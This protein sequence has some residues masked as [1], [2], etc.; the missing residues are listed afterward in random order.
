MSDQGPSRLGQLVDHGPL[1]PGLSHPAGRPQG[2][3]DPSANTRDSLSTPWALDK[4]WNRPGQLVEPA[5]PRTLFESCGRAGRN[6]RPSDMGPSG[7][8]QLVNTAGLRTQ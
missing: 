3:S 6:C 7:P 2:P 4:G 1:Y 8:G 5:G